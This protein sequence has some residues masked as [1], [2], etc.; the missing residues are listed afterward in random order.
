MLKE[1]ICREYL[2]EIARLRRS[3]KELEEEI[4]E[5]KMQIR[6]K[7]ED[8]TSLA[9]ENASLR[10][11]VEI[12]ERRERAIMEAIKKLRIPVIIKEDEE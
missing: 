9:M 10:H 8:A 7:T 6:M 3:I 12:L 11:K 4:I 2:I 1:R 5:L